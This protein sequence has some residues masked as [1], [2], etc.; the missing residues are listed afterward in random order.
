[1]PYYEI[2]MENVFGEF[3]CTDVTTKEQAEYE[4]YM[5]KQEFPY[6]NYWWEKVGE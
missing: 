6:N 1:M 5:L 3:H 4:I 2:H